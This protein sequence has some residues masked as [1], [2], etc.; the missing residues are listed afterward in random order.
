MAECQGGG[1]QNLH[2][3]RWVTRCWFETDIRRGVEFRLLFE[4]TPWT[5]VRL[6]WTLVT[7]QK[8]HESV[9]QYI[10]FFK[11]YRSDIDTTANDLLLPPTD[12]DGGE[13]ETSR[14][15]TSEQNVHA[16][17]GWC[18]ENQ[19]S[20]HGTTMEG[21]EGDG[22]AETLEPGTVHERVVCTPPWGGTER[23]NLCPR[24]LPSSKLWDFLVT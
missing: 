21:R 11:R 14:L 17:R 10:L 20:P 8:G 9:T 22:L 18:V 13:S 16:P 6:E 15:N 4:M 2:L 5:V 23:Y 12:A 24:P 1:K 19:E 7:A 3:Y